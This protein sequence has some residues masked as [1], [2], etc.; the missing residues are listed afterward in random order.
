MT[1]RE[2]ALEEAAK[3]VDQYTR[4][5]PLHNY[6]PSGVSRTEKA[7]MDAAVVIAQDIRALKSSSP[8]PKGGER[9]A[10]LREAMQAVGLSAWKHAGEDAY[11]QGM[12]AGA[13]HQ[14]AACLRAIRY[15]LPDGKATSPDEKAASEHLLTENARLREALGSIARNTC[16]DPC[17]EAALVARAALSERTD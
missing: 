2:E 12:D 13:R 14:L 5:S 3:V 6:G 10:A 7:A 4:V 9:I 11:S 15:L 8:P 1:E 17:R 16:C